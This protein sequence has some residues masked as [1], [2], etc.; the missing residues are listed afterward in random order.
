MNEQKPELIKDLPLDSLVRY[1]NHAAAWKKLLKAN[2]HPN[3]RFAMGSETDI[4]AIIARIAK[5]MHQLWLHMQNKI[6]ASHII[7]I[8]TMKK[9]MAID[10][11]ISKET[12]AIG[13]RWEH[14]HQP[15][16]IIEIVRNSD[17]NLWV[18]GLY[19]NIKYIMICHI[20]ANVIITK[21]NL[22]P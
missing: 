15:G 10:T 12:I 21:Y 11:G 19:L 18:S 7:Q 16:L 8:E 3:V 1:Y 4:D 13:Q 5:D 17:S 2:D 20:S 14:K 6:P 9:E 22:L